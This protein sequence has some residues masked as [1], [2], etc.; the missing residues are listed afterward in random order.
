MKWLNETVLKGDLVRLEPMHEKQ[1][2]SLVN[3]A[4]DGNLWNLWFTSVP[5][6]RNISTYLKYALA[7]L[8][9]DKAL[10]FVVIDNQTNS[11]IGTTR[12]YNADSSHRRLEIGY[13]FYAKSYQ[14]TGVNT[15]CKYL[16]LKYAFEQL[17]TRRVEFR[18][19]FHNKASRTA[20][21]RI[22]AKQEGILRSHMIDNSETTR[23]T[24][25]FSIIENEWTTVRQLLEYKMK[26]NEQI[27][28]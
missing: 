5:S 6:Q 3:V 7:E 11:V 19:H 18:T 26:R 21:E 24:V 17:Q 4:S 8:H 27:R 23:D 16:L 25:V 10:P 22:G 1:Q 12:Y 28:T 9:N 2:E 14:R 15:E 13:T 20:I